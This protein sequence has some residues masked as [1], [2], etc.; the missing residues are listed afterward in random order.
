MCG[1]DGLQGRPFNNT[2]DRAS[3]C[4]LSISAELVRAGS[5]LGG[6]GRAPGEGGSAHVFIV[7]PPDRYVQIGGAGRGSVSH[8]I[9]DFK[10]LKFLASTT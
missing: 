5:G 9:F 6:V 3:V 1:Q 8:V 10:Y 4:V 2:H 7:D